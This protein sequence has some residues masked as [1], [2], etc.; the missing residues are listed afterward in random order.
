LI[1]WSSLEVVLAAYRWAVAVVLVVILLEPQHLLLQH[2][3]LRL[4]AAV[5]PAHH[6]PLL[7]IKVQILFFIPSP[8]P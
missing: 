4:V 7:G 1:I 2:I 6:H 5:Q 3:P 8:Q